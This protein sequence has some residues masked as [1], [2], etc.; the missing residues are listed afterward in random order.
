[1]GTAIGLDLREPFVDETAVSAFF[2][3]LREVDA[4]F[5]TYRETSEIS[6][7]M[8]RELTPDGAHDDVREVLDL[9]SRVRDES[10][11]AFDVWH[12]G[13]RAPDPTGLVKGWSIDRGARLLDAAGA[14]NYCVNAGG[15]VLARGE[16]SPGRPWRVGI[17]HPE[18]PARVAAVLLVRDLAVATSATYERGPHIVDPHSGHAAETLLS[19]TVTGPELTFADAYATAAFVMGESALGWLDGIP[20]YEGLA[21]TRDRRTVWNAGLDA[22]LAPRD[23]VP[24]AADQPRSTS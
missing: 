15:D 5:S 16:A 19:I 20:G 14:R 6:R 9:C 2:A 7:L 1:M 21:I 12:F 4:R 24:A 23:D 22:L 17:R 3:W 10:G 13:D 11:G 18:Q 8:R